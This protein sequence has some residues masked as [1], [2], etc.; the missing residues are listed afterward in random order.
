[1][2]KKVKVE[3]LKPGVFVHDFNCDW[4]GEN[5]RIDQTLIKDGKTFDIIRSWG[6]QEVYIDTERGLDVESARPV[7]EVNRETDKALHKLAV[8]QPSPPRQVSL[9]EELILAKSIKKEAVNVIERS[10]LRVQAGQPLEIENVYQLVEKMEESVI[11]NKD[12]L[13]LLTK[14][15]QKDEYTLMHSISVG[16]LVLALCDFCHVPHHKS[17]DLAVGAMFHDIGKTMI[18]LAVLNKPGKLTD[19]EYEIVKKHVEYSVEMLQNAGGLPAE[20]YDMS[21]H[22]HER[23]DGNGYP[24]GLKGDEISFGSQMAAICD[25][26]DAITSDRCYKNGME[27]VIGLRKL[28][29]WSDYHFNKDL[30]YKFI[31]CIG[32]YPIGTCVKLEGGL[33]GVVIGST[34]NILQPIVRV[35]YDDKKQDQIPVYDFDLSTTDLRV[36]SYEKPNRW[37]FHKMKIFNDLSPDIQSFC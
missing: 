37:D 7:H 25:V 1:M 19:A 35:F 18:P 24:H 32:V 28:Y 6:I 33:V 10:I 26:Y 20:A 27:S 8:A 31:R 29:E 2:I 17:L 16:S 5:V 36:L 21:L 13:L 23:L 3:Q 30:T 12:A 15:R 11:R 9:E 22:H 14:M 34:E 4:K